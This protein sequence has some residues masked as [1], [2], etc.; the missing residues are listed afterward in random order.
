NPPFYIRVYHNKHKLFFYRALKQLF[1]GAILIVML[2]FALECLDTL[3]LVIYTDKQLGMLL[4]FSTR[5]VNYVFFYFSL[6]YMTHYFFSHDISYNNLITI[7][8]GTK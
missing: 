8:S 4:L 1:S 5:G 6:A 7:Y 3:N 2:H